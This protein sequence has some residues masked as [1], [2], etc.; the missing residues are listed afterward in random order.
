VW[1]PEVTPRS[2]HLIETFLAFGNVEKRR[3]R[4]EN[5]MRPLELFQRFD[6]PPR[7][8]QPGSLV[9]E[10]AGI[11]RADV[12]REPFDHA[13]GV[14]LSFSYQLSCGENW[15]QE[16]HCVTCHWRLHAGHLPLVSNVFQQYPHEHDQRSCFPG[17][18]P[19]TGQRMRFPD[20]FEARRIS[21]SRAGSIGAGSPSRQTR[22]G[23]FE[24]IAA[25]TSHDREET[26]P[27]ILFAW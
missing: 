13:G 18:H 2:R 19:Q 26:A 4:L 20:F 6:E 22:T 15:W 21:S 25:P 17:T 11:S 16:R 23:S 5:R 7:R 8:L 27:R 14:G 1:K 3:R 9:A 24:D 10:R 12:F